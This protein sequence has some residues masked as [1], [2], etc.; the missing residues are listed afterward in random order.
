MPLITCINQVKS[1]TMVRC[2]GNPG[3]KQL[4]MATKH[5][6]KAGADQE[7]SLPDNASETQSTGVPEFTIM[8]SAEK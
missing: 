7:N 8:K 2:L 1:S 4:H 6:T 5:N 3:A